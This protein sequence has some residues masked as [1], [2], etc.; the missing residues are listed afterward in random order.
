MDTKRRSGKVHQILINDFVT[1]MGPVA[2][3]CILI[4]ILATKA[5][6]IV[7]EGLF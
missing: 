5:N 4:V 7:H 3:Q 1:Q 6:C 2:T